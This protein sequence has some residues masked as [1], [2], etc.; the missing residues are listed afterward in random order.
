MD[1]TASTAIELIVK[2]VQAKNIKKTSIPN[3]VDLD[4]VKRLV[5][6][7]TLLVL[8]NSTKLLVRRGPRAPAHRPNRNPGQFERLVGEKPVRTC[9]PML[10][11]PWVMDCYHKE[12]VHLG[13][14]VTLNILAKLYW[15]RWEWQSVCNGG[16]VGV[17]RVSSGRFQG[18]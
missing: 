1:K 4:D 5:A 2:G 16:A 9:V 13:E 11:R 17:I 6:Q 15:W 7:G 3:E 14:K 12:S 8:D 10:L 18:T